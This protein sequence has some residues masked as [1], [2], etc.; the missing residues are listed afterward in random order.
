VIV[1]IRLVLLL[2]RFPVAALL[3]LFAALGLAAAGATGDPATTALTAVAVAGFLIFS[4][5]VNDLATRR[6]T[7]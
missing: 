2:L 6:S 7:A 4:V 1:R 5:A 3:A